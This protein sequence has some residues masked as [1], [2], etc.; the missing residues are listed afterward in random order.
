VAEA[1]DGKEAN[2]EGAAAKTTEEEEDEVSFF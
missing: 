1:A 2:A